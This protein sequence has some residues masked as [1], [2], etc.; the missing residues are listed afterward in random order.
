MGSSTSSP[1]LLTWDYTPKAS[2]PLTARRGSCVN[3]TFNLYSSLFLIQAFILQWMTNGIQ[4][5]SDSSIPT[6]LHHGEQTRKSI[7]TI[8]PY[9]RTAHSF[10]RRLRFTQSEESLEEI[11]PHTLCKNLPS[12]LKGKAH[13]WWLSQDPII[14]IGLTYC[15]HI[16][17]WCQLLLRDFKLSL[18][19]TFVA[20]DAVRYT[21]RDALNR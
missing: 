18:D 17:Q 14:Q 13:T 10:V 1:F 19:E 4:R 11:S 20:L 2:L 7:T 5:T 21:V 8:P 9:H 16:E 15:S 12:C 6:C 3:L